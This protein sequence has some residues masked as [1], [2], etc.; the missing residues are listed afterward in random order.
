MRCLAN[1]EAAN[2]NLER[3]RARN[4]DIPKAESDQEEA[5]RKFEQISKLA[6][7]ELVELRKTRIGAFKK[8]LAELAELEV[9]Q[10]KV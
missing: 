9:K 6:K 4:R 1:Y 8:N 7:T 5:C 2:K 3:C 10:S